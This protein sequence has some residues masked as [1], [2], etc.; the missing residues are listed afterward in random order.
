MIA[1]TFP[2]SVQVIFSLS[3]KCLF[4][5]KSFQFPWRQIYLFFFLSLL[6]L[7]VSYLGIQGHDL[8]SYFLQEFHGLSSCSWGFD[9][10]WADFGIQCEAGVQL[11]SSAC[12]CPIVPASLVAEILLSPLN[13]LG[14]LVGNQLAIGVRVG[15]KYSVNRKHMLDWI[16]IPTPTGF[17]PCPLGPPWP[18][19]VSPETKHVQGPPVTSQWQQ[20]LSWPGLLS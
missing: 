15:S 8:S 19:R 11:H 13:V 18:A 10:S 5:Y 17:R 1:N 16:N 20:R 6:M 9:L 14:I 4:M 12:G 2:H 7:L 3:W